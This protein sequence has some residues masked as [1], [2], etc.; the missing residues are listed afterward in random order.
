MPVKPSEQRHT[1][2]DLSTELLRQMQQILELLDES[3]MDPDPINHIMG[4]LEQWVAQA[5]RQSQEMELLHQKVDAVFEL[6]S[7]ISPYD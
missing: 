3:A 5:T 4:F 6:V 1:S 2:E 7:R